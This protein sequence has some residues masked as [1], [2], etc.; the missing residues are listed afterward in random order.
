LSGAL[1]PLRTPLSSDAPLASELVGLPDSRPGLRRSIDRLFAGDAR[2]REAFAAEI[3][4]LVRIPQDSAHLVGVVDAEDVGE[5]WVV[6]E[7]SEEGTLAER[8]R[9]A[10]PLTGGELLTVAEA[11]LGALDELTRLGLTHGDPSPGNVLL[12]KTGGVKLADAASCRRAFARR[13]EPEAEL[14]AADRERVAAWLGG[15]AATCRGDALCLELQKA[16]AA[17]SADVAL[18]AVRRLT[19]QRKASAGPIGR[20]SPRAAPSPSP[21]PEPVAVFVS[22]GPVRDPRLVYQTARVVAELTREPLA[23]VRHELESSTKMIKTWWP[24]P[25]RAVI[26]ACSSLR[27]KVVVRAAGSEGVGP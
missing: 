4:A 17:G 13:L 1:Y 3:R 19:E 18:F 27:V 21:P 6:R 14:A 7:Y 25:A 16:L 2:V 12:T 8:L 9:E 22:L 24:D 20:P 23:S 15:A 11:V 5:P 10:P 26:D